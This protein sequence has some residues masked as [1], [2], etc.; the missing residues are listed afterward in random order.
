VWQRARAKRPF[1]RATSMYMCVYTCMYVF[2]C[3]CVCV[4]VRVRMGVFER[5]CARAKV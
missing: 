3:A 1:H 2:V 4:R 5:D